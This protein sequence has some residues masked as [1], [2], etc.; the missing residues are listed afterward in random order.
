[1]KFLEVKDL[2]EAKSALYENLSLLPAFENVDVRDALARVLGEDV[3]AGLDVP[4][5]DRS[6]MDGYAV[7][8]EDTFR[9]DEG[10]PVRL[11]LS[12]SIAAGSHKKVSVKKGSAVEITTGSPVPKGADAVVMVEYTA[13]LSRGFI[14]VYRP[15]LPGEN[16]SAA[17]SDISAGEMVLRKGVVLGSRHLGILAALGV[18]G[19]RVFKKPVV[20]ILSTGNEIVSPG[21]SLK[22]GRIYDINSYAIAGRVVENGGEPVFLGIIKDDRKALKTALL[23][24]ASSHDVIITTG[25]TSKGS[26][27][28][29]EEVVDELFTPGVIVHGVGMKDNS[30]HPRLFEWND[31]QVGPLDHQMCF[32]INL[33]VRSD[34]CLGRN[35]NGLD[36][37]TV[38]KVDVRL[39]GHFFDCPHH[40]FQFTRVISQNRWDNFSHSLEI[41]H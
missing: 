8:A 34:E 3:V 25:G 39:I 10:R 9:A 24:A 22:I 37:L 29:L 17:G 32:E 20:A 40:L 14:E 35:G 12:G 21:S 23:G 33:G 13:R 16:I 18:A 2:E 11:R 6:T 38:H 30:L 31:K 15:A 7:L 41:G 19:I 5:F 36:K 28:L 27:D 1:M 4:S 26:G